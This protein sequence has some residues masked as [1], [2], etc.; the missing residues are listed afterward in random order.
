MLA[1]ALNSLQ[2]D[3]LDVDLPGQTATWN[4]GSIS[5]S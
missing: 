3:P 5:G 2:R 4:P 1:A